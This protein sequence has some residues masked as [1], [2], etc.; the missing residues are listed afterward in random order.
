MGPVIKYLKEYRFYIALFLFVLIPIIAIDTTSRAPRD[1]RLYDRVVIA[2]T[3]PVQALISWGLDVVIGAGQNY[4]FLLNVRHYNAELQ[5]ENR[6]LLNQI[7][8]L[9]E[10]EQ[11]N[12]RL[13]KV[14]NFQEKYE[15]KTILARV[16]A[17]DVSPD[18]RSIR[19]NRGMAEGVKKNMAVLTHEG[20]VGR[21][22]RV[23]AQTADIVTM[24][25]FQ[26]AVDAIVERSRA[27]GIVAGLAEDACELKYAL[28]TDD[29]QV[30]DS[31]IASGLGGIFPKGVPIGTVA[32]VN[33]KPYGI[34]QEVEVR[35]A[36]DFRKLEEVIVVTQG[37]YDKYFASDEV[38][39]Q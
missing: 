11:E 7:S 4:V 39:Q 38:A 32:R 8:I 10:A 31:L 21:V 3:S 15:L 23:T 19:I 37:E 29:I 36:V 1:Y 28:R 34:S 30:G 27:R 12:L 2:I 35:P 5:E 18:F 17:K 22:L 33:R 24:L 16:I 9:R 26:S 14:L 6:K 20:I 25:D 13:R